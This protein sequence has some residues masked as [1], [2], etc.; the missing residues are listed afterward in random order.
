MLME[1]KLKKEYLKEGKPQGLLQAFEV[2]RDL[3]PFLILVFNTNN[4]LDKFVKRMGISTYERFK[5]P[6][7]L[8]I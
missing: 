4:N 1:N 3:V 7:L 8:K 5:T 6:V 2:E